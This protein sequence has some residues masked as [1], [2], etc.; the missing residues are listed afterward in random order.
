MTSSSPILTT[1][2]EIAAYLS[3]SQKTA[4]RLWRECDLP[5]KSVGRLVFA[6]RDQLREW[7][8]DNIIL[9]KYSNGNLSH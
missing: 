9:P 1:W 7:V 5:V 4:R 2:K 6:D 8:Q 3:I